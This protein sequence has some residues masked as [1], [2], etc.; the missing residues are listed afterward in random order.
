MASFKTT[1]LI[2]FVSF[3]ALNNIKHSIAIPE[4]MLELANMLHHT[5]Q[6]ETGASEDAIV[7]CRKG[8]FADDPKLKCYMHCLMDQMAVVDDDGVIDE[9]GMIAM[10]PDEMKDVANK[11]IRGCGTKRGADVCDTAF[12]THKCWY[13]ASPKDYFLP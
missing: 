3:V 7:N 12:Q 9:D 8:E 6:D 11:I 10:M 13:A 1:A 4:E 5:C 2:V